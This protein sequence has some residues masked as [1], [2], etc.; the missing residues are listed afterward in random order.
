MAVVVD[1]LPEQ[2][3]GRAGTFGVRVMV[4]IMVMV[5]GMA[6]VKARDRLN[7]GDRVT[8]KPTCRCA[9]QPACRVHLT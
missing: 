4:R 5:R 3:Q 9:Q 7:V 6:R 8:N 1:S 2:R